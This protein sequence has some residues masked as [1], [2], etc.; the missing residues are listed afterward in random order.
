MRSCISPK[1]YNL[2]KSFVYALD[3]GVCHICSKPVSYKNA[4]LDHVVPVSLSTSPDIDNY[5]N[6]RLAHRSCNSKRQAGKS[7][8]Q[9][10]LHIT[11]K[12]DYLQYEIPQ[13]IKTESIVFRMT[14]E[15]RT[16]LVLA[17]KKCGIS[18]SA[19]IR[20]LIHKWWDGVDF[21]NSGG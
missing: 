9:L 15:E 6:L 1:R 11:E 5:W 21:K 3:H 19:F 2:L 18:F 4:T 14:P 20:L 12:T 7:P 8:G 10:R 16:L 13:G 17:C